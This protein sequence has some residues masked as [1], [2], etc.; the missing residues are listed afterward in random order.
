MKRKGKEIRIRS[1]VDGNCEWDE[2]EITNFVDIITNTEKMKSSMTSMLMFISQ[3]N[4][5]KRLIDVWVFYQFY[6]SDDTLKQLS[7]KQLI[8]EWDY[9]R[10]NPTLM[11]SLSHST[12]DIKRYEEKKNE[13]KKKLS[14][15]EMTQ[16][17][18]L[19]Q[20]NQFVDVSSQL[21]IQQNYQMQNTQIQTS[22]SNT[23]NANMSVNSTNDHES[24]MNEELHPLNQMNVLNNDMEL[25]T[26][27]NQNITQNIQ[28]DISQDL[29]TDMNQIQQSFSQQL[30]DN[31]NQNINQ[32]VQLNHLNEMEQIDNEIEMKDNTNQQKLMSQ[33]TI[34]IMTQMAI[35]PIV[36]PIQNYPIEEN[37]TIEYFQNLYNHVI[38]KSLQPDDQVDVLVLLC[39]IDKLLKSNLL[40]EN[41]R[42]Y[43]SKLM[44]KY[45]TIYFRNMNQHSFHN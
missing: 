23:I 43:F 35:D 9:F 39:M 32:N 2:I 40:P 4:P 38:E 24:K 15:I 34:P 5:Y 19:Q 36:Q 21:Q 30:N 18:E 25:E 11:D 22:N 13:E 10:Q 12:R 37:E 45:N 28:Q 1:S 14:Q 16:N 41:D 31:L 6:T 27:L 8:T 42:L 33:I 29:P 7:Y 26:P 17:I 44:L 20:S 3:N